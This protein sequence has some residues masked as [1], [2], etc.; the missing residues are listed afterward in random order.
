[1]PGRAGLSGHPVF[2][3]S[4]SFSPARG[5]REESSAGCRKRLLFISEHRGSLFSPHSRTPG[6]AGKRSRGRAAAERLAP[7]GWRGLCTR[8]KTAAGRSTRAHPGRLLH[9]PRRGSEGSLL[10]ER[11]EGFARALLYLGEGKENWLLGVGG[12]P[13]QHCQLS[14]EPR[15]ARPPR[16]EEAGAFAPPRLGPHASRS[17]APTRSSRS[18]PAAAL[19][20]PLRVHSGP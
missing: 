16:G 3:S 12:G 8:Q 19:R 4:S 7:P 10:Q 13:G 20:A 14:A 6:G 9:L 2:L 1:M 17:P 5:V 15:P 18:P 11:P